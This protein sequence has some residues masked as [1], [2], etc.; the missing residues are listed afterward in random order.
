[1]APNFVALGLA[2]LGVGP[3]AW[4]IRDFLTPLLRIVIV[5]IWSGYRFRGE[6]S[7]EAVAQLLPF[8]CKMCMAQGV[9]GHVPELLGPVGR[10]A[11]P[12]ADAAIYPWRAGSSKR[13]PTSCTRVKPRCACMENSNGGDDPVTRSPSCTASGSAACPSSGSPDKIGPR[14]RRARGEAGFGI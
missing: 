6:W 11:V 8:A 4:V 2:V 3:W 7:R 12:I 13:P 10:A 14:L 9:A 5:W 1:M